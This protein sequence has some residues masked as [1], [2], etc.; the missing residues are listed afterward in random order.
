M[1]GEAKPSMPEPPEQP[2]EL[3]P[4]TTTVLRVLYRDYRKMTAHDLAHAHGSTLLR[5]DRVQEALDRL[6]RGGFVQHHTHTERTGDRRHTA[7][8]YGLTAMGRATAA[9]LR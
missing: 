9:K 1:L 4:E 3:D 2:A 8:R 7:T 6:E 5:E